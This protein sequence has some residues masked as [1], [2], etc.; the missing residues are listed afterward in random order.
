VQQA[1]AGSP[2]PEPF[3]CAK[4]AETI[5][6]APSKRGAP[7]VKTTRQGRYK[8]LYRFRETGGGIRSRAKVGDF[9]P[10]TVLVEIVLILIWTWDLWTGWE[11]IFVFLGNGGMGVT[12][13]LP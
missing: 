2:W 12:T 7:S 8:T 13:A 5:I 10:S 1:P 9:F 11:V 3:S 4:G 6:I